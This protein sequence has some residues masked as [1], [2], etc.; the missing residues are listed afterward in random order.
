MAFFLFRGAEW[1]FRRLGGND[2]WRRRGSRAGLLMVRCCTGLIVVWIT[3]RGDFG[4][5][6]RDIYTSH[7]YLN[8]PMLIVGCAAVV[9]LK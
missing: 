6:S 1:V 5:I 4:A 3:R 8:V 2:W 9:D 7:Q